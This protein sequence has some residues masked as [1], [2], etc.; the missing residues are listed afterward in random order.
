MPVRLSVGDLQ[1]YARSRGGECLSNEYCNKHTKLRWQCAKGHKWEATVV[2]V[3][4]H[5]NWCPHCSGKARLTIEAMKEYAFSK[6]GQCLSSGYQNRT[7]K[8]R[9]RCCE[10]HEW[11]ASAAS[12]FYQKSW[13]PQCAGHIRLTIEEMKALARDRNGECLSDRYVRALAPLRWRCKNGHEWNATPNSVRNSGSWCP[14]CAEQSQ[15]LSLETMCQIAEE[16]GGKCLST[17]YINVKTHMRWR[18]ARGHEW[19][20]SPRSIIH[21]KTWCPCCRF[22]SEQE[23]RGIIERLI[24]RKFPKRKP[25]WLQGLELDGYCE[26]LGLAFEYQG[27]QHSKVI[28][29]WHPN[30]EQDLEAQKVRDADKADICDENWVTVIEIWHD[31][32]DREAFIRRELS[33]LGYI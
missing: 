5:N 19:E 18:C 33:L 27:E 1:V 14:T 7:A 10:G 31:C 20:T 21:A 8:L 3:R 4:H 12:T 9:W 25:V 24:G 6:G 28:P 29:V 30:G 13:C 17:E 26:A 11:E 23:C 2:S 16:H 22:K 15:K 32:P